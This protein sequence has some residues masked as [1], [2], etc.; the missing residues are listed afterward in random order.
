MD[1]KKTLIRNAD[2]ILTMDQNRRNYRHADMLICGNIIEKIGSRLSETERFDKAVDGRGK[3]IIPGMINTHHH[4]VHT[5][6]RN[7][8]DLYRLDLYKWLE[9]I[10]AP[11]PYLDDKLLYASTLGALGDLLKT[12]C[13]TS[14]DHHYAFPPGCP[15]LV[16][17]QIRAA[18]DLGIRFHALRGSLSAGGGDSACRHVPP[19]LVESVDQVAADCERLIRKYH[20]P[21]RGAMVRIGLAPCWLVYE[22]EEMLREMRLLSERY[23]V[24]LHSHL[25]ESRGEFTFSKERHGCTPAEFADKMGYLQE[26]SYFAHCIQLT[27]SDTARLARNKVGVAHCPNSDMVLHSGIARIPEFHKRKMKIGLG[28]DGAASNNLSNMISE[29]KS[30]Y[31]IQKSY[32]IQKKSSDFPG[33]QSETQGG[34][35]TPEDVLYF[36]TA[37]GAKVLGRDDIGSLAPGMAADFVCL[38]WNKFQYAGGRYDPFAAVVFS[39]DARMVEQVYVNGELVVQDGILLKIN[40]ARSSA[41]INRCARTLY[42]RKRRSAHDLSNLPD[43]Q[44]KS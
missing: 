41:Y 28:V 4:C 38:D 26:G 1:C 2:W 14:V 17:A 22:T 39:G 3:I 35:L 25:A 16:D 23:G 20:D 27:R 36:A 44:K 30:A 21:R 33:P 9:R 11:L 8:A 15:H 12:G 24:S 5:L 31:I 19:A 40:E 32:D 29:L 6:L 18:S 42:L 7:S 34:G 43:L 13:T 10:Y 37:G